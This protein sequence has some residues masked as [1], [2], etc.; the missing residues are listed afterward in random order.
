LRKNGSETELQALLAA[1]PDA[2]RPGARLVAREFATDLGPVD[3]LLRD[4]EGATLAVEVKRVAELQAVEQ[5]SRYVERLNM[6][7]SLAPV[8]GVLVAQTIKPQT[9]VLAGARGIDCVEVDFEA[10]AG[11]VERDPTLF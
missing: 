9:R 3:L 2:I 5:L 8:N 11:R 7:R 4:T 10:L 1:T 6:D